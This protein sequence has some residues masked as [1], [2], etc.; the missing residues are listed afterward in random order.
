MYNANAKIS[1]RFTEKAILYAS[2]T[3]IV[4]IAHLKKFAQLKQK[5]NE[6][7]NLFFLSLSCVCV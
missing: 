1:H 3:E 2:K 7:A 4:M 5:T 6:R